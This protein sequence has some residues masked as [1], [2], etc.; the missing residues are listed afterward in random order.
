M[1]DVAANDGIHPENLTQLLP[2]SLP[3][4][5]GR[6]QPGLLQQVIHFEKG[7]GGVI[8]LAEMAVEGLAHDV[9]SFF[10]ISP[11][12]EGENGHGLGRTIY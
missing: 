1:G 8:Q 12:Q 11:V 2:G 7:H 10:F 5:C 6:I 3:D 9:E 4:F